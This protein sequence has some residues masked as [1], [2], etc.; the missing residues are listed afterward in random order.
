MYVYSDDTMYWGRCV[1]HLCLLSPSQTQANKI[2][3]D[4]RMLFA[5]NSKALLVPCIFISFSSFNFFLFI[6]FFSHWGEMGKG[7]SLFNPIFFFFFY[8][9]RD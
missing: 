7:F 3:Y 2:W 6:F 5:S 4:V 9:Y 8:F 1:L